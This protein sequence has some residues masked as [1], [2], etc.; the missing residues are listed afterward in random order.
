MIG[1]RNVLSNVIVFILFGESKKI[2][3]TERSTALAL[4]NIMIMFEEHV[5]SAIVFYLYSLKI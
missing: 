1:S 2:C 3:E 4:A 5:I